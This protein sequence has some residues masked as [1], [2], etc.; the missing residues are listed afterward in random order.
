MLPMKGRPGGFVFERLGRQQAVTMSGPQYSEKAP[1]L[2]PLCGAPAERGCILS[3]SGRWLRWYQGPPK[4]WRK[5]AAALFISSG[6]PVGGIELYGS[7]IEGI[8][9]TA[10]NKIVCE[11]VDPNKRPAG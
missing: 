11:G 2:C 3:R 5:I 1:V 7:Y 8:R 6:A 10:C 9:C 4:L